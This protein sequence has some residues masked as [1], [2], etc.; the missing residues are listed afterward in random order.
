MA[1]VGYPSTRDGTAG[2]WPSNTPVS[3]AEFAW[4]CQAGFKAISETGGTYSLDSALVIGGATVTF[5]GFVTSFYRINCSDTA[6][7]Q[8]AA[9]FQVGGQ[10]GSSPSDTWTVAAILQAQGGANFTGNTSFSGGTSGTHQTVTS[11]Q[12]VTWTFNSDAQFTKQTSITGP[13]TQIGASG[14]D[15]LDVYATTHVHNPISYDG[16]ETHNGAQSFVDAVV[17]QSTGEL[18][19]NGVFAQPFSEP[20]SS[21][22]LSAA[23]RHCHAMLPSG[24]S[25]TLAGTGLVRGAA[26]EIV[27]GYP[28]TTLNILDAGSGSLHVLVNSGT[29][30]PWV[31]FVWSG[32]AWQ[33]FTFG[34]GI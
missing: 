34:T 19:C 23:V 18:S 28:S 6:T 16:T 15:T 24:G 21:G 22:V 8:G 20:T 11:G 25:L 1:R 5:S 31:K 29:D 27:N 7:F 33:K 17:I 26:I 32:T 10:L 12:Y 13:V 9:T 14:T 30:K 4:F 2:S 3:S